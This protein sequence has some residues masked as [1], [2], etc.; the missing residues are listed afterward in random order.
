MP[1]IMDERQRSAFWRWFG[2]AALLGV[3]VAFLLHLPPPGIIRYWNIAFGVVC[4]VVGL[5]TVVTNLREL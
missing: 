1:V 5:W 4:A 2:T 3:A